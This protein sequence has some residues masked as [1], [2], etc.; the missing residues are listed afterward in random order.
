MYNRLTGIQ[1]QGVL[2]VFPMHQIIVNPTGNPPAFYL[3]THQQTPLGEISCRPG[4]MLNVV[5]FF[6]FWV[7][8]QS[9]GQGRHVLN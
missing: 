2:S 6:A 9:L 3:N 7:N 4:M 8:E 5:E 1:I